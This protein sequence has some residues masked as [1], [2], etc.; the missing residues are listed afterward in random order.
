MQL[1]FHVKH[2]FLRHDDRDNKCRQPQNGGK[3]LMSRKFSRFI[4]TV[5]WYVERLDDYRMAGVSIN[6]PR[7]AFK[8]APSVDSTTQAMILFPLTVNFVFSRLTENALFVA[9]ITPMF[10]SVRSNEPLCVPLSCM[11][12]LTISPSAPMTLK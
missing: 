6:C 7:I 10:M 8:P 9:G 3:A 2:C 4:L 1:G 11:V 12:V 5:R